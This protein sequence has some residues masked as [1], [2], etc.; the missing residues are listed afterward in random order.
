MIVIAYQGTKYSNCYYAALSVSEKL[1]KIRKD[2]DIN[3]IAAKSSQNVIDLLLNGEAEY[4]LVAK[5]NSIAGNVAETRKALDNVSYEI[6]DWTQR[7]IKHCI[8]SKKGTRLEDLKGVFSHPHALLQCSDFLDENNLTPI[9]CKDTATSALKISESDEFDEYGCIS[10]LEAGLELDLKL[11]SDNLA[12]EAD[13][14]TKFIMITNVYKKEELLDP[15]IGVW[16]YKVN[17]NSNYK[18]VI[19]HEFSR[20]LVI[21][22]IDNKYL[23]EGY[24]EGNSEIMFSSELKNLRYNYELKDFIYPDRSGRVFLYFENQDFNKMY[25]V[26]IVDNSPD[27]GKMDIKRVHEKHFLRLIGDK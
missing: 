6:V 10:T 18:S 15:I 20:F 4:G 2:G 13:N 7:E 11:H 17:N 14:I 16:E 22:K 21:K 5:V 9:K 27:M 26:F 12:N 8:F 23:I 19:P 25:G 1:N 3:L 24:I